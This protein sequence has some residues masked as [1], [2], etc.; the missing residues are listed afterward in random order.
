MP[1]VV[2]DGPYRFFF[3]SSEGAEPPHVHVR[4][5]RCMAKYWL[6]PVQLRKIT[7][8]PVMSSL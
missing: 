1:E 4:R 7:A 6:W 8:L 3:F 2:R 5:D